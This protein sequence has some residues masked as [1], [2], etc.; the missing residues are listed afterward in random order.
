M[1]DAEVFAVVEAI[2]SV[3]GTIDGAKN[4]YDAATNAKSLPKAF[5]EV[6]NRLLIVKTILKSAISHIAGRDENSRKAVKCVVNAYKEK[7]KR[8]E[9]LFQKT[10]P[11]E[12]ASS[13]KR[14][15]K[16][17]KTLEK[18]NAVKNL[19][20]RMLK[21]VQRLAYEHSMQIATKAKE[22]EVVQAI[23]AVSKVKAS[24]P[25]NVFH[26]PNISIN[27]SGPDIQNNA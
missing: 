26:D 22:D 21:D 10:I 20:K 24:M 8:L 1:S 9:K 4:V 27:N 2:T 15:Y 5:R 23:T 17:V 13:L 16:A 11:S 7:S 19:I 18:S 6:A 3:I 14:Y 12:N 25:D